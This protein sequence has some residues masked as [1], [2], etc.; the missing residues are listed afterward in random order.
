MRE[1]VEEGRSFRCLWGRGKKVGGSGK[2]EKV[3]VGAGTKVSGLGIISRS[4]VNNK[5]LAADDGREGSEKTA[6][7]SANRKCRGLLLTEIDRGIE[8]RLR[9]L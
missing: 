7:N 6:L 3:F 1:S 4:V 5:Q 9:Y 8:I 2:V